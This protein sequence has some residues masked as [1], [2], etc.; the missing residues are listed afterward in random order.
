MIWLI[1]LILIVIIF[2]CYEHF[3]TTTDALSNITT[4]IND[5]N[6]N[7]NNLTV[8]GDFT[9]EE[10]ISKLMKI[11]YPVDSIITSRY[12]CNLSDKSN[13]DN[14]PLNYGKW[15]YY[16]NGEIIEDD[17]N[18]KDNQGKIFM[19]L[20]DNTFNRKPFYMIKTSLE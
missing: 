14:L 11:V 6:A 12:S 20:L 8:S 1:L 7:F 16:I 2:I 3:E 9:N 5:N 4:L 13:C 17:K 19:L 15:A 10:F 18:N